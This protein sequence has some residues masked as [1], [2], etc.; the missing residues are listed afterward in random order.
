MRLTKTDE[1]LLLHVLA[2]N[3]S[4]AK[5]DIQAI[6]AIFLKSLRCS[7]SREIAV[8][9]DLVSRDIRSTTGSNLKMIEDITGLSPWTFPMETESCS[10]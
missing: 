7:T 2:C 8:M 1:D 10:R 3:L 9:A 4:S 5:T 6:Y